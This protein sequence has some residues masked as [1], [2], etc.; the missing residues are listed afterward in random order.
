M[1]LIGVF[2]SALCL[3][4]VYFSVLILLKYWEITVFTIFILMLC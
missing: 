2:V 4:V 3:F 1:E